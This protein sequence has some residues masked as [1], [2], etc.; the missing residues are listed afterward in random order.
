[1]C[2]Q[3]KTTMSAGHDKTLLLSRPEKLKIPAF[4]HNSCDNDSD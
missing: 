4:S 3:M 1:M 2:V